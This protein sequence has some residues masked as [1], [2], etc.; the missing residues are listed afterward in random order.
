[1]SR[2]F[3]LLYCHMLLD[4]RNTIIRS[5][6]LM[7]SMTWSDEKFASFCLVQFINL[8][9][10]LDSRS[11]NKCNEF[12]SYIKYK[13]SNTRDDIAASFTGQCDCASSPQGC[14]CH[15]FFQLQPYSTLCSPAV[16]FF[17]LDLF[18]NVSSCLVADVLE[19]ANTSLWTGIFPTSQINYYN[20][21]S[22]K[23]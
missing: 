14:N 11:S 7:P 17:S 12:A 22:E 13:N 21:T 5:T 23:E 4:I 20:T 9:I 19:I 8:L 3:L 18:K 16:K 2:Q 1:M 15:H 10:L 6:M